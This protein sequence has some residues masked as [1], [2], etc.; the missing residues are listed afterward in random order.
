MHAR[1]HTHTHTHRHT[2]THAHMCTHTHTHVHTHTH[3]CAHTH[4]HTHTH[5]PTH[6][7]THTPLWHTQAPEGRGTEEKV[8]AMVDLFW[9]VCSNGGW[10]LDNFPSTRDLWNACVDKNLLPD[11][12]ISLNDNSE[13]GVCLAQRY[14]LMN[15]ESI[16]AK[17]QARLQL[18][19][20]E[21]RRKAEERR[22]G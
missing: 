10:I 3:A 21:K 15:R 9:S 2:A 17:I 5:T 22:W 14:Y 16:D 7:H 12:V 4:T 11:D 8:V 18:E 20:E 13:N 6:T 1:L 19:E